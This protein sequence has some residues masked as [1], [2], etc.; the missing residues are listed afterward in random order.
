VNEQPLDLKLFFR[1]VWRRRLIVAALA[2]VGLGC[3]IA[4]PV[5]Q[6]PMPRAGAL[7][8]LPASSTTATN[9]SGAPASDTATQIIIATSTPVLALAGSGV[10]PPISARALKHDVT[11]SALSDDVLQVEVSAPRATEAV[12]LANAV[13]TDY[14]AYLN[15]TGSATDSSVLTGFQQEANALTTQIQSLQQQIRGATSRL[16]SEGAASAAG[17]RDASLLSSLRTEQEQVSLELNNV[18]GQIVTTQLSGTVTAGATRVLQTAAIVPVSDVGFVVDVVA[19]ML[20]GLLVGC[21]LVLSFSRRDHRLRL[22]DEVAVA[23]GIPVV[24]SMEARRCDGPKDWRRLIDKYQ[25]PPVD[26]WNMRRLLHRLSPSL[27]ADKHARLS[28]VAFSTDLPALAAAVQLARAASEIGIPA[29]FL[30]GDHASLDL[31]RAA[32]QMR[33]IGQAEQPFVFEAKATA[34]ELSVARLTMSLVAV[35]ET[36]P[37]LWPDEGTSLL[38]LSSGFAT[39]EAV[40]RVAL[41]ASDA[42]HP[43]EGVIVVNPDPRDSTVGLVPQ[44]G[45][46]RTLVRVASHRAIMEGSMGQSK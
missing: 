9:A 37:Q 21:V 18:N 12:Q 33:P 27:D 23:V 36:R 40:A 32:C 1:L 43:I 14:I 31:L 25:P 39:A 22:R 13:S 16:A 42:G 3:G 29:A 41:M 44:V 5:L 46:A 28:I 45:E 38:A 11:V 20:V 19:G 7:V 6:P 30:P 10:R 17:E 4:Y 15:K 24:V 34:P 35:D 2:I 26:R 8:I